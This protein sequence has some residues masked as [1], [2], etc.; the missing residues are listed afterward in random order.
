MLLLLAACMSDA[1]YEAARVAAEVRAREWVEAHRMSHAI[2]SCRL[3]TWSCDVTA[4][5]IPPFVL[6][7]SPN[8][9]CHLPTPP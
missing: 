9:P 5:G 2:V 1:E 4:E 3:G 8:I 7:C 6:L